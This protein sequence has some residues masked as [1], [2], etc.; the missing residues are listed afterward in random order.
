MQITFW[1]LANTK[2]VELEFPIVVLCV[3]FVIRSIPK[4]RDIHSLHLSK[5]DPHARKMM[6]YFVVWYRF[7]HSLSDTLRGIRYYIHCEISGHKF[8]AS[9][10]RYF[11]FGEN[12]AMFRWVIPRLTQSIP[13]TVSSIRLSVV[14]FCSDGCSEKPRYCQKFS[15][16]RDHTKQLRNI[17]NIFE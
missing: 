17:L 3:E 4:Y 6:Q 9:F 11:V 16:D 13:A 2:Y 10:V 8:F 12:E 14:S 1:Y 15:W 7:W 5:E